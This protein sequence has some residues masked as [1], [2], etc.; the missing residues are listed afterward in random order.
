M[1]IIKKI[2]KKNYI[3]LI[4]P[5]IAALL[6]LIVYKIKS[7]TPFGSNNII[8]ADLG[9]SYVSVYYYLRDVLLNGKSL[10]Y[11]FN[12]GGGYVFQYISSTNALYSPLTMI[13]AFVKPEN[14]LSF[15]PI[16]LLIKI[17][18]MSLTMAI[19]TKKT[20]K[21]INNGYLVIFSLLY[22]FSGYVLL[23]FHNIIWLDSLVLF[24]LLVL[25]TLHLFKNK[26]VI[27][28]IVMLFLELLSS[29][30]IGY[31]LLV[32]IITCG[33]IYIH[34]YVKKEDKKEVMLKGLLGVMV[35]LI[36]VLPFILPGFIQ[37]F[38]TY[39]YK[40]L[41][42]GTATNDFM[43]KINFYLCSGL[44]LIVPFLALIK[45][46]V[47]NDKKQIR[48]W[49]LTIIPLLLGLIIEK[50]NL[51]WHGGSYVMFPYRY[52]FIPLFFILCA[53]INYFNNKEKDEKKKKNN[54]WLFTTI[55]IIF[56]IIS[57]I[58]AK[59]N[60]TKILSYDISTG[61]SDKNIFASILIIAILFL[62]TYGFALFIKNSKVKVTCLL[63]ITMFEIVINGVMYFGRNEEIITTYDYKTNL[64]QNAVDY[65]NKFN[66]NINNLDRFKDLTATVSENYPLIM[67]VPSVAGWTSSITYEQMLIHRLWG[68]S[69][70]YTRI[71]D[72]GG[73]IFSDA[74][75]HTK[76]VLSTIDL[77][78]SLYTKI[79]NYGTKKLYETTTLPLGIIHN[80]YSISVKTDDSYEFQNEVYQKLFDK[81]DNI[82]EPITSDFV[83]TSDGV[84][85][86]TINL[87]NY[88]YLYLNNISLKY[89][90]TQI[91]VNDETIE[92]PYVGSSDN[93]LY[94][95]SYNN[96][97]I[98]LGY[99]KGKV[100]IILATYNDN[101]NN[102][103]S[104]GYI[105]ENKYKDLL[106][107]YS[108]ET[109]T[110]INDNRL[111]M[112][113][114]C[115]E[116]DKYLL[117][118]LLYNDGM[119]IT[120]NGKKVDVEP[121]LDNYVNIKLEKGVNNII[122]NAYPKYYKSLLL[123]SIIT[124]F[125]SIIIIVLNKKYH[126]D[127][128]KILLNTGYIVFI[129]GVIGTTIYVYLYSLIK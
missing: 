34:Y 112:T 40:Y 18:L 75:Y 61:L 74:F 29:Y 118:P 20:F 90:V 115:D 96:G 9:Q 120:I 108:Y 3:Y 80:N 81:E 5:I 13:L 48:Y 77:S 56:L 64:I 53:T 101:I 99:Y 45:D 109:D 98:D 92:I 15:T 86:M 37:N 89:Y 84:Y 88:S 82:I 117:I 1:G 2:F 22:A 54:D 125:L 42:G 50:I 127:R 93:T 123:L 66:L 44:I 87:K 49:L 78:S 72:L 59:N 51:A 19:F 116:D 57:I 91:I 12:F 100:K 79:D 73:T 122:I 104:L 106:S 26:K 68:Y 33:T 110:K 94:P 67:N 38:E 47:R 16:F 58:V 31:M 60:M 30:Y 121:Y 85:S 17:V 10:L 71:Q 11:S 105:E 128:N 103:I 95:H 4:I 32:T 119:E 7:I 8:E 28:F 111:T 69:T 113:V 25:S 41:S 21:N 39:R 27:P 126:F 36:L 6:L 65:R 52:G 35:S 24:P 43:T 76:Y 14:L 107:S 129:I 63:I 102:E 23:N 55:S 114:N 124:L 97:I 62:L 83:S 46:S 70:R